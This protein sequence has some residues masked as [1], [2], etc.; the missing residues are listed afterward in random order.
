[1]LNQPTPDLFQTVFEYCR[2]IKN[3][4]TLD[5]ILDHAKGEIVEIEDEIAI[6]K[7]GGVPGDDGIIGEA[8]DVMICLIDMIY[9]T[10]PDITSDQLMAIV[11]A[12]CSKWALKYG[13]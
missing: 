3:D 6:L 10:N 2:D 7:D 13:N 11:N 9:R 1:M 5:S 4:R 12:K 8:V